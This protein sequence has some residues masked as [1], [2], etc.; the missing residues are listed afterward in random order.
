M[1]YHNIKYWNNIMKNI[2]IFFKRIFSC[3][4]RMR[5]NKTKNRKTKNKRMKGGWKKPEANKQIQIGIK[6]INENPLN[7]L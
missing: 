4:K 5:K 7:P 1:D 2:S 6:Q 3:K